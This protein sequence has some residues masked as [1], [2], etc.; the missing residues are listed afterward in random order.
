MKRAFPGWY[1]RTPEELS[2]IW[3]TAL[4]VPDANVLLH[5]LRH[6]SAVRDEL[7]R[8]FRILGDS[9]WVPH[10][11]GLE[12]H[13]HRLDV[14][15]EAHDAYE[16]LEREQEA[17]IE[18]ARERVRQLR[19]HPTIDV[20]REI[21][22]LGVFLSDFRTRMLGYKA[23]H[24]TSAIDGAVDALTALLEDRVGDKWSSDQLQA[25]KKEGE[26]RY[27]K[28]VPPGFKDA[29]KD[30]GEF[31]KFGDLII[32]KDMIAKATA[33][34]RPIIFISDDAKEDWWW[35]HK[36][37]KIGP[38]PEL[39]EEF[40]I[41]SKQDFHMYEFARFLHFAAERYPEMKSSVASLERSLEEDERA[42]NFRN[43]LES[44][45]LRSR[46]RELEDE[47]EDL[48][49]RLAGLPGPTP[50]AEAADRA[51]LRTRLETVKSEL[52]RI[53]SELGL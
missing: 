2:K 20:P 48:V 11:V 46:M 23:S 14:M 3:E 25:L 45:T 8:V 33:T 51:S 15:F 24:P 4:F 26:E 17:I 43:E 49:A 9:L 7:L 19:A 16:V 52:A 42:R 34:Q 13:R 27:A 18:K 30:A 6:P 41:A 21:E 12:F 28:K 50:L 5:C 44:V 37:R 32:W 53:A 10:Q 22:A 29:K 47:R 1:A 40:R 35:L 38:R 39:I 31:D 36:G